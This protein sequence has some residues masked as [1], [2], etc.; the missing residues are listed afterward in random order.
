LKEDDD[1]KIDIENKEGFVDIEKG[2]IFFDKFPF[3]D[4]NYGKHENIC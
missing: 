2:S 1:V 3:L 4:K